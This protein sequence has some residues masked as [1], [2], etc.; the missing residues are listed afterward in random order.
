[1]KEKDEEYE[2]LKK[3]AL[4]QFKR[5]EPLL[6]KNGAFAPL[7]KEFLE[8]ALDA[9]V[10]EHLDEGER[11]RGNRRNGKSKKIVKSSDGSFELETPR[12]REGT[13]EPEIVK[14]RVQSLTVSFL[15]SKNGNPVPWKRLTVLYGWMLCIIK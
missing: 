10:E 11:N 8:S 14:K 4:E 2:A 12:D 9:E 15:K 6:G 1:M 7:L 3:K 13:F 5:G